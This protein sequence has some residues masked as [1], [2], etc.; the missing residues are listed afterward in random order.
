MKAMHPKEWKE[1]PKA[2]V[3]VE[4]AIVAAKAGSK[5]L[6]IPR[7][8]PLEDYR[9][10]NATMEDGL[11]L[12]DFEIEV[13]TIKEITLTVGGEKIVL[14]A[15][16]VQKVQTRVKNIKSALDGGLIQHAMRTIAEYTDLDQV[17]FQVLRMAIQPIRADQLANIY[18][19]DKARRNVRCFS[20]PDVD[21]E[22]CEWIVCPRDEGRSV[23]QK[24]L[25]NLLPMLI[26]EGCQML[27]ARLWKG[28]P[29]MTLIDENQPRWIVF[30]C[31]IESDELEYTYAKPS[32]IQK[33]PDKMM[34]TAMISVIKT[35]VE[36]NKERVIKLVKQ[37][38]MKEADVDMYLDMTRPVE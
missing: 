35:L 12:E 11:P 38:Q 36:R 20:R 14:K 19:S 4:E 25:K 5:A 21:S 7:R 8:I 17:A 23:V 2:D 10:G 26:A 37:Y 31:G 30:F 33:C 28:K 3:N 34:V 6:T 13:K 24:H 9:W 27:E 1:K 15:E 22:E 16:T 32:D 29:V 18:L